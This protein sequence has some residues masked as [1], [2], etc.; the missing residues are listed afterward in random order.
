MTSQLQNL[1]EFEGR[2]RQLHQ[3]S[4]EIS[5]KEES[6]LRK[7][8]AAAE[9]QM[10]QSLEV[11]RAANQLALCSFHQGKSEESESLFLKALALREK[12]AGSNDPEVAESLIGLGLH[13]A[14]R[15][16]FEKAIVAHKRALS[17][18]EKELGPNH[19]LLATDLRNLANDYKGVGNL[20]E[21]EKLLR[22]AVA[23]DSDV[24]KSKQVISP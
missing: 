23:I 3:R 7:T 13:Y 16:Q 2:E 1:S 4:A 14:S 11:A 24:P 17:I 10:P 15:H 21:A 12:L 8:L 18:D 20:P 6:L 22:R 5:Q 9:A 19:P